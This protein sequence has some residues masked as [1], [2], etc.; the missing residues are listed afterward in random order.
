MGIARS[1][2]VRDAP[3]GRITARTPRAVYVMLGLLGAWA[4]VYQLSDTVW[5]ALL[6]QAPF[7]WIWPDI[8]FAAAGR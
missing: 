4:A 1:I 5:P 2:R 3:A 6:E 8:A 7:D